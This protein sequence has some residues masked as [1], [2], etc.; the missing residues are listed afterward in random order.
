[1]GEQTAVVIDN[2]WTDSGTE[3][4]SARQGMLL[5]EMIEKIENDLGE[6]ATNSDID[7]IFAA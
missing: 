7:A 2:L 5:R 1:M 3:A 6:A 4:L